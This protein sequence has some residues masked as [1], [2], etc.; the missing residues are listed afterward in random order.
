MDIWILVVALLA[1]ALILLIASFY[2]KDDTKFEET[3]E[4]L[5]IQH[6]EDLLALK[7]R[8]A[9]IETTLEDPS[10]YV[11][12]NNYQGEFPEAVEA[13]ETIELGEISD[14]TKEEVIRLYSQGYTMQE[15][16]TDVALNVKTVQL[17]VDDYIENR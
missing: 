12:E 11:F 10:S 16:A 8:V 14:L 3:I 6:S 2:A 1:I 15:I 13:E 7:N 9:E 5:R 17:I 4:E